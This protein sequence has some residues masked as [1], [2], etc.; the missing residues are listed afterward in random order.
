[1]VK[2]VSNVLFLGVILL[3]LLAGLAKTVLFPKD[4]N[5][6]ENR[7]ASKLT[8]PTV[9]SFLDGT[10]Q[11]NMDAALGDQVNLAQ[12]CKKVYHLGTS[13]LQ[14]ALTRPI[15]EAHPDR[16]IQFFNLRLMAGD[17]LVYAPRSLSAMT[18]ALD[19]KAANWNAAFA[20]LPDAEFCF[21]YIE[22]DTDI[23]FETGEKVGAYE[24]F[25]DR[26]TLPES[27]SARLR[28]DDLDTFR[29]WF[30]RT[31]HHWNYLGSY[32]GYL[33]LHALLGISETPLT[34]AE[35]VTLP[36]PFSG[37]KARSSKARSLSEPFTAYRFDFPAMTITANGRPANDYGDQAGFLSGARSDITYGNFYGSD[38]GEIIFDTGTT[39]RGSLLVIGESYDNA[40]LKLLAA[41]YD[42]TY[43]IDL[44][45]YK[46]YMQR[47]FRLADYLAEHGIGQVLLMG[48]IDYLTMTEFDL[49]V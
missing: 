48:N 23:N 38:L 6:Y 34:P 18:E 20:A 47:D 13:V 40:V 49:E 8:R 41:H 12:T 37:S 29:R 2:K 7:Y 3:L 17:T 22:K 25:I 46:N 11:S 9:S 1:M 21:Y 15:S 39:G 30:Y 36:A 33:E 35:T 16:Y 32:E 19:A 43:S 5:T 42:R 27:S 24:Y 31:D 45:Y 14:Y 44:R 10:F 28:V 4:I 26:L